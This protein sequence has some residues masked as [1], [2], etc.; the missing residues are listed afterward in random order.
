MTA[1]TTPEWVHNAVFYQIFPDRFALSRQVVK[2]S[3][4]EAWDTPPSI[5]GFKGGDLLGVL[6]KLDYLQDLGINA[7]YFNPIF[8]AACSH[9]YHTHDYFQ[10]D[11]LL[12]GNAAFARLL[13]EAHRSGIKIVLDGVFNHASRGF[14]QFNHILENGPSSPYVDWFDIRSYPLNAYGPGRANYRCWVD[15]P[16]LPELNTRNPQV[17]QYI[18]DIA[19]HWLEQGI[20]GWRLDVP[21]CIDDDSFWQEF[22]QVVKSTNPEAY[23]VGEVPWEAQRWLQGDQFD[24]VMNYQFTQACVGFFAG[25]RMN[26]HYEKGM[27]GLPHTPVMDASAFARRT[28][29]LLE[30][31]PALIARAQMNLLDSHDMPRF[32]SIAAGDKDTLKLAVLFMLTYPGA[33]CIY[34]GDEIGLQNGPTTTPEDCRFSF[35]WDEKRWDTDLRTHYQRCIG[36]RHVY[37]ALRTG[38]FEVVT[39]QGS[40]LA[41]LR[42]LGEQVLL[43]AINNG[44]QPWVLDV[45]VQLVEGSLK[46]L[47]QGKEAQT[48]DGRLSGTSLSPRSGEIFSLS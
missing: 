39:A 47:L 16:A 27:M 44:A 11:P 34:Y 20:D 15:L 23:I 48:R 19:R 41:F 28:E 25:E 43:V 14:F 9:R 24:A 31:Y 2:P 17:R 42:R 30:L 18:M 1:V 40:Q 29:A 32:L 33:P 45:P 3:N 26:R 10:V 38:S 12:G 8:Q 13:K 37:P 7:I 21:F 46:G 36:L 22:R 6:E 5:Y 4:L 35:P